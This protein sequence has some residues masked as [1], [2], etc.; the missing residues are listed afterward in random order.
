[1]TAVDVSLVMPVWRPRRDWL[2]EAVESALGQLG[3]AVELVVV[4][5]G[6]P[7]PVE[8]LL[9]PELA[10]R[11]RLVRVEHGGVA[12]ARNAA[13]EH[14]SG[15]WVRYVDCDDVLEPDSSARLLAHARSDP[16]VIAYGATLFCDA[17]LRPRWKMSCDVSG[18]VALECLLGR[19]T[20]RLP[21]L[22]FS[23]EL[24]ARTGEWDS[25]L[26]V[27]SD[28]DF[29]L[30][31]LESAVVAG[32]DR[33][34]TRYRRHPASLTA[35]LAAGRAAAT[36]IVRSYFERHPEQRGTAVERRAEAMLHARDARIH[37]SRRRPLPAALAAARAAAR[38]PRAL[39]EELRQSAVAIASRARGGRALRR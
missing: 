1:V 16:R 29:V 10:E 13:L 6:C 31:A 23:R 8:R 18:E 19:L 15:G 7:E 39:A 12:R 21:S 14:C 11:L 9:S 3:C 35:D 28:W 26:V 27:S 30:R 2:N 22:L 36:A 38:D 24:V 33:V 17:D 37:A 32:D 5:D 4:D 20:V 34:A 25:R